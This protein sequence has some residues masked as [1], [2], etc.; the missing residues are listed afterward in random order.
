MRDNTKCLT[1]DRE[2]KNSNEL[3]IG[4]LNLFVKEF[5]V[6]ITKIM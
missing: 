6:N 3:S 4:K 2:K 1:Q 5:Q